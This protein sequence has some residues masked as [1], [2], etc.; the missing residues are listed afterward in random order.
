MKMLAFFFI[1]MTFTVM[2][3]HNCPYAVVNP[4]PEHFKGII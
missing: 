3:A 2:L 1:E 4:L